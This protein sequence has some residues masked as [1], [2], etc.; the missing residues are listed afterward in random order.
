MTRRTCL[1]LAA[2]AA[3]PFVSA[4]SE[5]AARKAAEKWLGLIDQGKYKDAYKQSSQYMR[6][7]ATA[8]EWEPQIRAMREGAGD[9]Q[10]R[11]FSSAK[12]T[13]QMAGAP[14]GDYMVLEYNTALTKKGKAVETVM[15]SS[16]GGGWKT[17]GYFIR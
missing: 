10:S 8:E 2:A 6:A 14:D 12:V 4:Q 5:D 16:E 1:V 11:N 7:Q 9:M 17:A 3:A 15:M 13:K